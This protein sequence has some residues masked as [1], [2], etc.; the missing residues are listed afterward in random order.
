MNRVVI[1]DAKRTPFGRFRGALATQSA[2]DLAVTAAEAM[3]TQIDRSLVDQV[4]LGNVLSAGQGMNVAR[5][6]AVKLQLPLRTPAWSVNMM[7]GSGLQSALAGVT[8]IRA[9]EARVVLAGG[10]ESM[11]QAPLLIA[12]PGKGQAPDATAAVDSMQRDG[13][14]DSFSGRH[15][16]WQA[17]DLANRFQISRQTQDAFAYRSQQLCAAAQT[18]GRFADELVPLAEL[19]TDQHPR[20]EVSRDD[21][22]ALQPVFDPAGSVTAGNASGVNDGAAV[23]LLAE[24]EFALAQGW[25]VLAEWVAGVVVGVDPQEMG[26]GPVQAIEALLKRTGRPWETIDTLEINEAFAAQSLAC[27]DQLG[28]ALDVAKVS[29]YVRLPSGHELEFNADGGAIAI[30]H[31]LAASGGRVLGHLAW[32]IARGESRSAIGSLCIGGGMGIAALLV[33]AN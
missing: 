28:L 33:T 12:R 14:V 25:P 13:L 2:V 15:M 11:S 26:L 23:V 5:Q 17:E 9:G 31:P 20:L 7:C 21:L 4:I 6:V 32:K 18:A 29:R 3:L 22:A 16:G 30:G 1:V 24:R 19:Q 27:L 8:A 10:T